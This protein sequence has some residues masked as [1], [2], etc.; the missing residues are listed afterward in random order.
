MSDSSKLRTQLSRNR[1]RLQSCRNFLKL[2][3]THTNASDPSLSVPLLPPLTALVLA[4][5]V[6]Q[7]DA[8]YVVTDR[9]SD[10]EAVSL[11][12]YLQCPVISN[13]SDFYISIPDDPDSPTFL[14]PLSL[15]SF[16]PVK[17]REKSFLPKGQSGDTHICT[18]HHCAYLRC[19][20]FLPN[21]PG[22]YKL[23]RSQRPLFGSLVGNDYIP[24]HVFSSALPT[25]DGLRTNLSRKATREMKTRRKR[26]L[27]RSIIDWLAGFGD[28]VEEPIERLINRL[29]K[30]ERE[31]CKE[32][33]LASL[34]TYRFDSS[35]SAEILLRY[36]KPQELL[37]KPSRTESP[38]DSCSE[39]Q[40]D[41]DMSSEHS[42]SVLK[43]E[44]QGSDAN[45]AEDV[46]DDSSVV[47]TSL[48]HN[49]SIHCLEHP[50]DS[51]TNVSKSAYDITSCWPLPLVSSFRKYRIVPT[52][53]DAVYSRGLVLGCGIEALSQSSSMHNCAKVI[54]QILFG[55][56]LGLEQDQT[57]RFPGG[58]EGV[59]QNSDGSFSVTEYTR[60]GPWVV[61]SC[62][63]PVQT[64]LL[65]TNSESPAVDPRLTFLRKY[66]S[67]GFVSSKEDSWLEALALLLTVWCEETNGPAEYINTC[68]FVLSSSAIAI[69]TYLL[70]N[71]SGQSQRSLMKE[72]NK[73]LT[74]CAQYF[75]SSADGLSAKKTTKRVCSRLQLHVVHTFGQLQSVY[76]AL[77]S[78]GSLLDCLASGPP[79]DR[80]IDLPPAI[81]LFPSGR[82]FH[83][84]VNYL[85]C[86]AP[87]DRP[88]KVVGSVLPTLLR[89]DE[90]SL[91][92]SSRLFTL[93]SS[94]LERVRNTCNLKNTAASLSES[95][96]YPHN[97]TA[98]QSPTS[99]SLPTS[100]CKSTKKKKKR[101][102]PCK[103]GRCVGRT[104]AEINAE[105]DRIML[106]N[107]LSD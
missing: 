7:L 64:L 52:I 58:L 21:G 27:F 104:A 33:L 47:R 43:S 78:L 68:S 10:A 72:V 82:L 81:I 39:E 19:Y 18:A 28:N 105:V 4:Q 30:S 36:L 37:P 26:A 91:V 55:L 32:L 51:E 84:V 1:E 74:A 22:L 20:R 59:R 11:A 54:R 23:P 3:E 70:M 99:Q 49:D 12:I 73:H 25:S 69:S 41:G 75:E 2:L 63:I 66:L 35:C 80:C 100:Q 102:K 67:S 71:V 34:Q 6:E 88:K 95:R 31:S 90:N 62:R 98:H 103:T 96:S 57:R 50:S 13:D 40:D 56:L 48:A 15:V 94:I 86:F 29:P 87:H 61:Q 76:S 77:Y 60:K 107:G 83:A 46:Q 17:F 79:N 14:L 9:E 16:K 5:T 24:P 85:S 93:F 65:D 89:S 8:P 97:H 101:H 42:V 92:E 45:S 38:S 106:A 53:L 44:S